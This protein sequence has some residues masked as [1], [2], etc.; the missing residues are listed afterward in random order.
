MPHPPYVKSGLVISRGHHDKTEVKALQYALR[1]LG[2]LRRG[3]DGAFGRG[4]EAAVRALQID[5]MKNTGQGSDGDAPVSVLNYNLGRVDEVTGNVDQGLARCIA[6]MMADQ[7]F[8]KIP[9]SANPKK[10]NKRIVEQLRTM[11]STTVPMP[12]LIAILKTGGQSQAL[13]RTA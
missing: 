13:Q 9:A 8:P 6:D 11:D 5:L 10:E 12:Y 3:I 7:N 4:T 1:A 2:Y